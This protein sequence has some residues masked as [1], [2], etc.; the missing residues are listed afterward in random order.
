MKKITTTY[1]NNNFLEFINHN[2]NFSITLLFDFILI[3]L[4]FCLLLKLFSLKAH[5]IKKLS[6]IC[7]LSSFL[8][9]E[10]DIY[11]LKFVTN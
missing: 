5:L 7:G 3:V 10:Q 2:Y 8:I 6:L 1:K 4:F 11:V 9:K